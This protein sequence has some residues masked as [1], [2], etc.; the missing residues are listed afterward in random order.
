V[1]NSLDSIGINHYQASDYDELIDCPFIAGDS[2]IKPYSFSANNARYD[3]VV[4]S[5]WDIPMD[6]L[7]DYTRQAVDYQTN[8][9]NETPFERYLF[10]F[11]FIMRGQNYGA[12]E[13]RNSSV[14]NMQPPVHVRNFRK[15]IYPLIISHEFFHCWNPKRFT[16]HQ[17]KTFDYQDTVRLRH[18][19]FIEGL[20]EY[21]AKLTMVRTGLWEPQDFLNEMSMLAYQRGLDNLEK[22][23]LRAGEI[24]VA[25]TMYSQGALI[26][27]ML[28]IYCREKTDNKKSMDDILI[29]LNEKY[30]RKN[31]SFDEK[32]FLS[33]LK[34]ASGV[35]F[36]SLHRNYVR[37]KKLIPVKKYFNKAGLIYEEIYNPLYGWNFDVDDNNQ[38][39]VLSVSDKSTATSIG[40]QAGDVITKL[41]RKPVPADLDSIRTLLEQI[42]YLKINDT[43]DMIVERDGAVKHIHGLIRPGLSAEVK[44]RENPDATPKEKAI[45]DGILNRKK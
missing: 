44:I 38:L 33:I 17:L 25:P 22:L 40:L 10:I 20:T 45:L 39:I 36:K 13:H 32:E 43:I 30:A 3:M 28:D 23:S 7:M 37:A 12:M 24:G 34:E 4:N 41:Q 1:W 42:G 18:L 26:A 29:Y 31:K 5:E 14:Y 11:N 9:F 19:W 15:S 6:S 21:Y 27:F 8:L 35:D 2:T 16:F